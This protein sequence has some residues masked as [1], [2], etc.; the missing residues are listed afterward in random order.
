MYLI[1]I[2]ILIIAGCSKSEVDDQQ[3]LMQSMIN[4]AKQ[5]VQNTYPN[6]SFYQAVG[7]SGQN[8]G[9]TLDDIISWQFIFN[10]SDTSTV[11]LDYS[12]EVYSNLIFVPQMWMGDRIIDAPIKMDLAEAFT[13]MQNINPEK[14]FSSLQLRM[15]LHPDVKEPYYIF[16]LYTEEKVVIIETISKKVSIK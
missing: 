2:G 4:G 13:L 11:T 16:S 9:R 12:G 6:T 7:Y 5:F 15:P 3:L 8:G 1:F 10:C 14:P